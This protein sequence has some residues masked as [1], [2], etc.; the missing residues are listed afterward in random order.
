MGWRTECPRFEEGYFRASL[1]AAP[2]D[3]LITAL[4]LSARTYEDFPYKNLCGID[5]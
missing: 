4:P 5:G 1:T 3:G 2:G